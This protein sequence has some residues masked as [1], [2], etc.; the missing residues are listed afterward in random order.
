[1]LNRL[2]LF[3]ALLFGIYG[4][5]LISFV[6]KTSFLK[7]PIAFNVFFQGYQPACVLVSFF[8]LVVLFGFAMF[9]PYDMTRRFGFIMGF[10]YVVCNWCALYI[11]GWT[12][13]LLVFFC[14][15]AGIFFV[16]FAVQPKIV[17]LT[18]NTQS[19]RQRRLTQ[20]M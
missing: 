8:C 19:R 3:E 2:N 18:T 16:I 12:T 9:R 13:P 11:E 7:A 14:I 4:T 10:G 5:W 20:W 6:D 1:M 15:G 17:N